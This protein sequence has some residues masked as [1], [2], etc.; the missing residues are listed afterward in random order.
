MQTFLP[1]ASFEASVK[2]LDWR[3]LGKQRVEAYQLLK[4]QYSNHPAAKM[5]RDYPAALTEYMNCCIREWI[6]RGYNNNMLIVPVGGYIL[7]AWFGDSCLHATHRANLLR[8]DP[9]HYG[10][11]GWS[12]APGEGYYWPV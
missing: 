7:P 1:V 12:E 8:K 6:T 3:R 2:I 11:F 10:R 4:G 9:E 5:W